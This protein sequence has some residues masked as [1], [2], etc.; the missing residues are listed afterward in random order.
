MRTED[1][2]S[3]ARLRFPRIA[4]NLRFPRLQQMN[5][6]LFFAVV[7]LQHI[8]QN[9]LTFVSFSKLRSNML[10]RHF[11]PNFSFWAAK[12]SLSGNVLQERFLRENLK[13]FAGKEETISSFISCTL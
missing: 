6:S 2:L 13:T 11:D 10:R 7:I 9:A 5:F 4:T 3:F 1:A 8:L 12:M